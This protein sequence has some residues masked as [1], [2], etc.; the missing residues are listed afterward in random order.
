MPATA[1]LR[2]VQYLTD[3]EGRR[4]THGLL[5]IQAWEPRCSAGRV[6]RSSGPVVGSHQCLRGSKPDRAFE[7]GGRDTVD[8]SP[9]A[10]ACAMGALLTTP[11]L[12][13]FLDTSGTFRAGCLGSLKG[14]PARK[15]QRMTRFAATSRVYGHEHRSKT[16]AGSCHQS[17]TEYFPP[18]AQPP[19]WLRMPRLTAAQSETSRRFSHGPTAE[20]LSGNICSCPHAQISLQE[21][22]ALNHRRAP[23]RCHCST[24]HKKQVLC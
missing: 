8:S 12:H 16:T 9:R 14:S 23:I 4:P 3:T 18:T 10:R 13:P 24:T 19:Q 22:S 2:T 7:G 20:P 1:A 15:L 11:W 17:T 6:R 21:Y 5:D